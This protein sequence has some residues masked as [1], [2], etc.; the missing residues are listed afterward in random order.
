MN[1]IAIM[2]D[3]LHRDHLGCYGNNWIRTPN[4]DRF[5]ASAA[6]F[7]NAYLGSYPYL[8]ARRD[9][10]TGR[11][12]FP[13]RGWGGLE[14]KDREFSG[15]LSQVNDKPG[16]QLPEPDR[17]AAAMTSMLILDNWLLLYPDGNY[18]RSFAGWDF[19]RGQEGDRWITDPDIPIVFPC[20]PA[21]LRWAHPEIAQH[22]RNTAGRRAESD[23]F[24]P[25]VMQTAIDWLDRNHRTQD[26]LLW[27]D[28]FD[29][30]EP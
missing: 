17:W 8:P 14:A 21:K 27:I 19:I 23:W 24:A 13:F 5:A 30:H 7:D 1:V 25:Q 26:F 18:H 3:S 28:C 20:D 4:I 2:L 12:E 10:W 29:P 16:C 15:L 11:Y 9:I 6:I 22:L